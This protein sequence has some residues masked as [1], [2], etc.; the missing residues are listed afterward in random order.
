MFS[1]FGSWHCG[2]CINNY[3]LQIY[4]FYP[5]FQRFAGGYFGLL[6]TILYIYRHKYNGQLY[7]NVVQREG[8]LRTHEPCGPTCCTYFL[9][10][11]DYFIPLYAENKIHRVSP[12]LLCRYHLI[13]NLFHHEKLPSYKPKHIIGK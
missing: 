8:F 4:P 3:N 2:I 13:T 9:H 7:Q 11:I 12:Q 6:F 1:V 10:I 5:I